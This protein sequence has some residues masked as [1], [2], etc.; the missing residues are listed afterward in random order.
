MS[1]FPSDDLATSLWFPYFDSAFWATLRSPNVAMA[2]DG[3]FTKTWTRIRYAIRFCSG[4]LFIY[5]K[6][7]R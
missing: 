2:G 5:H 3:L 6:N 4:S 7:R 1:A